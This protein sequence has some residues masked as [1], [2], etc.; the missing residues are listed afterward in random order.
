[1]LEVKGLSTRKISSFA[2]ARDRLPSFS[3]VSGSTDITPTSPIPLAGYMGR[4]GPYSSVADPLEANVVVISSANKR[5]VFVTTDLLYVGRD[6]VDGVLN[7]LKGSLRYDELFISA[8]HT[9]HAPSTD[10]SK[11]LLGKCVDEYLQMVTLRIAGLIDRLLNE[12]PTEIKLRY[13]SDTLSG[14]TINRRRVGW[15]MSIPP[16]HG[17]SILPNPSGFIDP[18]LRVLTFVDVNDEVKAVAWNFCCHPVS[19]P[20]SSQ[21]SADYPGVV[22]MLLRSEFGENLPV[23][24]FQGFA[25]NVKPVLP[26]ARPETRN[27]KDLALYS[28]SRILNGPGFGRFSLLQWKEWSGSIGRAVLRLCVEKGTDVEGSIYP[29]Y[30]LVKL[31]DFGFK[32][33]VENVVFRR[34]DIGEVTMIGLPAEPVAEYVPVITSLLQRRIVIP[35]GCADHVFGYLPAESMLSEGGYEVEGFVRY[36]GLSGKFT[37]GVENRVVRNIAE[38]LALPDSPH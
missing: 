28:A 8:S 11:P 21:V 23:L 26:P 38:G 19:F 10:K 13:A 25:G 35:V 14:L 30:R 34:V 27:L 17:M 36:F 16:R 1:M 15:E 6:L 31:S 24:F 4:L 2:S 9:H 3:F 22:R 20:F 7:R 33:T 29:S 18:L 32:N 12:P 5:V 37:K